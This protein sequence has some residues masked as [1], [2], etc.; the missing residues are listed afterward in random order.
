M[1]LKDL[2]E[3]IPMH[4]DYLLIDA[5]LSGCVEVAYAFKDIADV[6][7]F[8]PAEVLANGFMYDNI[9]THLLGKTPDPVAV[10]KDYY[11]FYDRQT[12]NNRSATITAVAPGRMD[13]L[14]AVCRELFEKYR[15]EIGGLN[16]N[17]VQGYFRFDHH[18]FY[19]LK[20]ILLK[21]GINSFEE[22]RLDA[23]LDECILYKAATPYFLGVPIIV[24]SGLSMYLPSRGSNCYKTQIDW[25]KATELV[26]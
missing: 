11:D 3:A 17:N 25:N 20:D 16:G 21:A 19:D 8:S 1:E 22:A 6:V 23:A 7:G 5:C 14:A 2:V 15:T 9:T 4:L 24:Y 13:N 18:Y 26:K 10:C 12:G